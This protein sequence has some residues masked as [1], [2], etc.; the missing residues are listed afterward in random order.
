M[1]TMSS[2]LVLVV[3]DESPI[4]EIERRIL[5][6]GGYRVVEADGGHAA[7]KLLEEGLSPDLLI[8]D[9]D[10]PDMGGEEMVSRIHAMRPSQKVLYVTANIDR[11][12]NVRSIVWE[13]EAFLEKPFTVK[14]LL[15]AASLL[16]TGRLSLHD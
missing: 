11:L 2:P 5:E 3:D 16:L 9:L 15:E 14:G 12:L 6:K 10:M 1:N 13:G 7:F 8:A 4:R